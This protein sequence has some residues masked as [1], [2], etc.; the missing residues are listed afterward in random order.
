ML[1]PSAF[2]EGAGL[3]ASRKHYTNTAQVS[4]FVK[5][6]LYSSLYSFST[7]NT[8]HGRA[9]YSTELGA[10]PK[11]YESQNQH[12]H[13]NE[14]RQYQSQ[15]L[16]Q[17][18]YHNKS[19]STVYA[20]SLNSRPNLQSEIFEAHY[21]LPQPTQQSKDPYFGPRKKG[22]RF[23]NNLVEVRVFEST[24]PISSTRSEADSSR[25]PDC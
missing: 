18:G 12:Q 10:V 21:P 5:K 24:E 7:S 20:S 22:V 4:K 3:G 9:S 17:P 6:I 2:E 23:S 25:E 1:G 19:S 16:Y 13:H 8:M 14:N 11:L 15:Q